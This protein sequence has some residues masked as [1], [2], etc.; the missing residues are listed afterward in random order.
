MTWTLCTSGAAIAK[1]GVNANSTI[2]ASGARLAEWC[3]E[4][5]ST[6]CDVARVDVV[7]SYANLKS[8]GKYILQDLCSSMIAQ[9]IINYDINSYSSSREAET[10]LDILENN[11][12]RGISKVED[13][14][15]KTYILAT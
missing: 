5:E 3:D 12:R 4:A 1:A 14:K 13:D 2:I 6:I 8:N 9:K 15:I 10:M 11:I 7:T